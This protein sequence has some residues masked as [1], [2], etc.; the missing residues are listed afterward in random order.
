MNCA[1][2]NPK[3]NLSVNSETLHTIK[4]EIWQTDTLRGVRKMIDWDRELTKIAFRKELREN[5]LM[6]QRINRLLEEQG[7]LDE[8]REMLKNR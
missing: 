2:S 8:Y 1:L 6:K 7:L 5:P 4:K 3:L